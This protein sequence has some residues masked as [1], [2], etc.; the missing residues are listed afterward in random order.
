MMTRSCWEAQVESA[1]HGCAL[2]FRCS[3]RSR[4][5][6]VGQTPRP[7][8][9]RRTSREDSWVPVP[10]ALLQGDH[11]VQGP[12][13]Q[14]RSQAWVL[15]GRSSWM[16]LHTNP[17]YFGFLRTL[18]ERP[19]TPL[20]QSL[21]HAE[22]CDHSERRQS[23]GHRTWLHRRRR[24]NAGHF[25]P[26]VDC[27]RMARVSNCTPPQ[28]CA[29]W[30]WPPQLSSQDLEHSC[31]DQS[32]TSQSTTELA[33][34]SLL[35]A[36]MADRTLI[37]AHMSERRMRSTVSWHLAICLSCCTCSSRRSSSF[38]C[39]CSWP[40]FNFETDDANCSE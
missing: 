38:C 25:R 15:Q 28:F 12:K 13:V 22:K 19:C 40:K 18:R 20:S 14:S 5:F 17:P 35:S 37:N 21:E 4:E 30:L 39:C 27:V 36:K 31:G 23:T 29:S 34:M 6:R 24:S 8:I 26:F 10:Q 3:T 2:H 1:S 32:D 7:R 9:G 16:T 33:G 11:A